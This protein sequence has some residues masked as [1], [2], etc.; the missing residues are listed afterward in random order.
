M[1]KVQILSLRSRLGIPQETFARIL[2]TNY[3]TVSR[4]ETGKARPT[5]LQAELLTMVE[6]LIENTDYD[7]KKMKD[8]LIGFGVIGTLGLITGMIPPASIGVFGPI[9]WLVGEGVATGKRLRRLLAKSPRP[10]PA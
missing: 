3:A 5:E 7:V 8:L 2:R 1:D 9:G 6:G 10:R 4:W